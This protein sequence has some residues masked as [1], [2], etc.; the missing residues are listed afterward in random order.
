MKS[1]SRFDTCFERIGVTV[2]MFGYSGFRRRPLRIRRS[3]ET[4]SKMGVANA[5]NRL[6]QQLIVC[7]TNLASPVS[8][9]PAGLEE[10]SA[11]ALMRIPQAC[12]ARARRER[13]GGGASVRIRAKAGTNAD[14]RAC[15]ETT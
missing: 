10:A 4:F 7:A 8:H 11:N 3:R 14:A 15:I 6:C 1:S 12:Q 2:H 5:G 9:W 13:N